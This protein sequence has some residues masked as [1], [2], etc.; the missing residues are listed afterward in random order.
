MSYIDPAM[1]D[2]LDTFVHE[3]ETMLEQLDEILL[4]SERARSISA[5]NIGGIFRITHTIKG[6]A[7]MMGIDGISNLSHAVEDVFYILRNAPSKLDLVFDTIFDLV[8]QTSDFLKREL[9]KLQ[10]QEDDYVPDDPSGLIKKLHLQAAIISGEGAPQDPEKAPAEKEPDCSVA[11]QNCRYKIHIFFNDDSQMENIR[12]FM[13]L[14]QL[15]GCCDYLNS[16]PEHPEADSSLSE[17]IA[18][19]GFIVYCTPASS[20]DEVKQTIEGNLSIKSYEIVELLPESQTDEGLSSSEVKADTPA[21][22]ASQ[23]PGSAGPIKAPA[24]SAKQSLISVNQSKLDQLM[25]LVGEIVTAESM[26]GSNPDLR[27]LKLDNFTKSFRE[28]RKL[29]NELQDIVMAIRMVPLQTTFHKMD[30]IVRD[31]SK[32]LSKKTE[33]V[34][35]GG[36]TEVDKTINDAM[37]DPFMHMIRNSMDHAIEPPEERLALGKPEVGRI[38]LSARNVGG[39]ILIEISDD[40][41]GLD[42]EKLLEKAERNGVLTKPASAYTDRE[43]FALIMAPG[44]STN[45]AVTEFSGR[46]V[47]MDVVRKNVEQI[48]GTISINSAKGQGTTFTIKIPLTLAIVN[49]MNISV[50]GTVLTLPIASIS[51]SFKVNDSKQIIR[52]TNGTEMII[53]RGEC[54]PIVRLNRYFGI[55]GGLE[56]ITDGIMIQV[57]NND[58]K[59]CI[60]ADELIGEFQVVVK[61][62]PS[63]FSKYDLKKRGL[64]GCSILG[65]GS[66]SLILDSNN[67]ICDL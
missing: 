26:V 16:D 27:G 43:A 41:R 14:T 3:T 54:Y 56:D 42:A 51:Q 1:R 2:M 65:D 48:G 17:E 25:D 49:G 67:L 18:H 60:F 37:V 66:I 13:L 39:E 58:S 53:I 4:E 36:D 22:P 52:N 46:G 8:F 19:N 35:E 7:A 64:S 33:L 5:D 61:P 32:K 31:M 62:F 23:A 15:E 10:E 34:T 55:D 21:S 45:A 12:A 57:N 30:R 47:G 6:S 44:F 63:F 29:T 40:G 59:A 9:E 38:T 50:G 11:G 28:L 24:R 20:I